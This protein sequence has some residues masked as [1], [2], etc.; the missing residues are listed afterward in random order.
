M[1]CHMK[2]KIMVVH[3]GIGK[4]FDDISK[5]KHISRPLADPQN[6]PIAIDVL[7]SDP[8]ES[9]HVIGLHASHRGEVTRC[10]PSEHRQLWL[11][12]C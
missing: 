12:G 8:T 10:L 6:D 11:G 3:G 4:H 7:W 9:D 1:Q 2:Q 5:A